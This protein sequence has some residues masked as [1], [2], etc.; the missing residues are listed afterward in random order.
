MATSGYKDVAVANYI[1][2][3]YSW[4]AG[5]QN[6]ASN[7]TP[8]S[9]KLQLISSN[10]SANINSSASKDYSVTTDGSKK[11]GTNTVGLSGGAT[12]TLAS[13]SKNIYHNSDGTKT[14]SYSF[15]QEFAITY[16]GN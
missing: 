3:R 10:S 14:F 13:G 4:T 8:I 9:W 5:T 6:V 15:S 7:Y 12:K 16:S 1:T 11:T 2:L